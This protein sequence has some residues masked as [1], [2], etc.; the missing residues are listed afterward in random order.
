ME[1]FLIDSWG[2]NRNDKQ[3]FF[4]DKLPPYRVDLF[5]LGNFARQRVPIKVDFVPP[6]CFYQPDFCD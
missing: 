5:H 1:D 2:E 4:S 3:F 6:V